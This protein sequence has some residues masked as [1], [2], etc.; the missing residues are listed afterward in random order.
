M[1]TEVKT[2]RQSCCAELGIPE[3]AFEETVLLNSFHP[4][5]PFLCKLWWRFARDHFA[6]DLKLIQKV[7]D[8]T[9]MNRVL[10]IITDFREQNR[11]KTFE[12]K[13]LHIRMSGQRLL[14]FAN[15]FLPL[16]D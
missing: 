15:K 8:C 7:A 6:R 1:T 12:R 14:N 5:H 4:D 2:F 11:E 16:R 10:D 3:E 9:N 13:T